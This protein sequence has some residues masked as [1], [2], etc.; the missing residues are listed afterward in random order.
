MFANNRTDSEMIRTKCEITSMTK[1][2]I[3]G[4]ALDAGRH[5]AL[6]GSRRS[7]CA[8]MPSMWY[9]NH[10]TSVSASGIEMFAVAA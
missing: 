1:I 9:A 5:P 3:G 4:R 10:T 6:A 2:G 8:R 7:P